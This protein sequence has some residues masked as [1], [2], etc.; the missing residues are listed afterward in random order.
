VANLHPVWRSSLQCAQ[1][2]A[3]GR[4]KD[5]KAVGIDT[6]LEPFVKDLNK[7]STE[8]ISISKSGEPVII[9]GGLLAFLADNLASHEVA[10][11]KESMSFALRFCRSCLA[12]K[13]ESQK[14]FK[15]AS[16]Q[17]GTP[18]EH[19]Q[20]CKL[21]QGPLREHH[22]TTFGIN[23]ESVL[24]KVAN[25]SV[26]TGMCHDIMHDLFEGVV[27][28]E[29]KLLLVHCTEKKYFTVAE[30][31]TR[32]VRF[33]FGYSN[34]S[35]RPGEIDEG[36]LLRNDGKLRFSAASTWL[37]AKTLPLIIG[38][39][40]PEDDP[41]WELFILLCTT[42]S[43]SNNTIAYLA[44]LIEEHH[45]QFI[46]LYD[47]SLIPK[48]HFMVHYPQQIS[49]FGP[50]INAWCM[51]MESKLK[52]CK[53]VARYGN[54]KNICLSVA[55]SHQRWMCMQLQ[56]S[57]FIND[58]VETGGKTILRKFAEEESQLQTLLSR[59]GV[60]T[61][62]S[63]L[64]HPAWVKMHGILYKATGV[65]I[66]GI[67]DGLPHFGKI[68]DIIVLSDSSVMLYV[69]LFVTKYFDMHYHAY[70]VNCN[71]DRQFVQVKS[72]SYPFVLHMHSLDPRSQDRFEL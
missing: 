8:G 49:Q 11:F 1:L 5:I 72:L 28:F 38:D 24:E 42:H 34:V 63:V 53:R 44:T 9:K 32:I 31:N 41:N 64:Q 27:P 50:L 56:T 45:S 36:S 61:S 47:R 7:L 16:F 46:Q 2:V 55:N 30:L 17:S 39:K 58:R 51:R 57:V 69:S 4:T 70:V 13:A 67:Q 12:T 3:V 19:Q 40:V 68:E 26:V 52:L 29:L 60:F 33:D 35:S 18:D 22:S 10:G 23:R 15:S 65:V 6:F 43:C 62:E 37:L 66:T 14:Y 20:Q 71:Q 54:F 59:H 21:L 48:M 25:F